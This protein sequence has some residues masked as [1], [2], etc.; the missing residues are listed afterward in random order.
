[1]EVVIQKPI[2]MEVAME[3]EH[4]NKRVEIKKMKKMKKINQIKQ[5]PLK[6]QHNTVLNI[7]A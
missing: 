6:N 4:N 3:V 1:M 2:Q 7:N 5:P